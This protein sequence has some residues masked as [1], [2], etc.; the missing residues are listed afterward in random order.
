MV[1]TAVKFGLAAAASLQVFC[2]VAEAAFMGQGRA[3]GI[4]KLPGA[5]DKSME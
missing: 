1:P 2:V 4:V 3:S 5:E